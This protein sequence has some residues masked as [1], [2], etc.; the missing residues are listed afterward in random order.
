MEEHILLEI[1]GARITTARAVF[2]DTTF[3]IAHITLVRTNRVDPWWSEPHYELVL[4]TSSGEVGAFRTFDRALSDET[5]RALDDAIVWQSTGC[6]GKPPA[7][8]IPPAP[9]EPKGARPVVP[10]V[11]VVATAV[12]AFL[13]LV[14]FGIAASIVGLRSAPAA[15]LPP[16]PPV[17]PADPEPEPMA[18]PPREWVQD[19]KSGDHYMS[20]PSKPYDRPFISTLG[21]GCVN[22]KADA[23]FQFDPDVDNSAPIT[24]RHVGGAAQ[25]IPTSTWRTFGTG[26][27]PGAKDAWGVPNLTFFLAFL[28]ID[29]HFKV[30]WLDEDGIHR[31]HTFH[32]EG[33]RQ[34]V[35]KARRHCDGWP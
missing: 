24:I 3:P 35:D 13:V 4:V 30:E 20:W 2:M 10:T 22:G 32:L 28:G 19:A 23:A 26:D 8:R 11:L 16:I 21:I 15:S 7:M 25:P 33:W 12:L 17:I 14:G 29:D 1:P 5:R 34:T 31:S 27:G 9:S 6:R 18:D